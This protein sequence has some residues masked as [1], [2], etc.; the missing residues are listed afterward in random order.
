MGSPELL[1]G[2]VVLNQQENQNY[3]ITPLHC[4]VFWLSW[5]EEWKNWVTSFG[6]GW[7][8][9][10]ECGVVEISITMGLHGL[11]IRGLLLEI[12]YLTIISFD[13]KKK[14]WL[15]VEMLKISITLLFSHFWEDGRLWTCKKGVK[16]LHCLCS[17]FSHPF[18]TF[19]LLSSSPYS[20]PAH[21]IPTKQT[22]KLNS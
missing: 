13:I 14:C 17:P 6:I 15:K 7:S 20:F 11:E 16:V 5:Q 8:L 2:S 1:V 22:I 12:Y 19:F 18:L 21:L 10:Q 4:E 9:D 3:Y